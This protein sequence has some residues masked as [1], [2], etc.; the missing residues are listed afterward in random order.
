MGT[1]DVAIIVDGVQAIRAISIKSK[2]MAFR[3]N[4]II[5]QT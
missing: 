5:L 4:G 1:A 2:A 3:M